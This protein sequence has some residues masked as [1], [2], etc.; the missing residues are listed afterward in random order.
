M[1]FSTSAAEDAALDA[2]VASLPGAASWRLYYDLPDAGTELPAD[3]GY[4]PVAYTGSEW[5]AASGGVKTTSAPVDFGTSTDAYGEVP[6]YW[7][8]ADAAGDPIFW[9][10][11][12]QAV[13]VLAAGTAVSFSPVLFFR[14]I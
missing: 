5:A 7:G 10:E 3:G 14:D 4:A 1:P 13:E 11:L 9:D 12:P 8:I 6:A 2:V